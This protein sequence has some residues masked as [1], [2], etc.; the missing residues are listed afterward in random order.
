[1]LKVDPNDLNDSTFIEE[2]DDQLEDDQGKSSDLILTLD[3][4]VV[5]VQDTTLVANSNEEEYGNGTLDL[6]LDKLDQ[7]VC[8]PRS[9]QLAMDILS[10]PQPPELDFSNQIAS[11]A[12]VGLVRKYLDDNPFYPLKKKIETN[13]TQ[14]IIPKLCEGNYLLRPSTMGYTLFDAK[15]VPWNGRIGWLRFKTKYS[16]IIRYDN[17]S[18]SETKKNI[19]DRKSKEVSP[20]IILLNN[21]LQ[22]YSKEG[23]RFSFFLFIIF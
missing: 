22:Y 21:L 23:G 7:N 4:D 17:V 15:V 8:V 1:M 11:K 19:N 16:G 20:F 14:Q 10:F 5:N 3:Q 12:S 13:L 6:V 18:E 9:T 2:E